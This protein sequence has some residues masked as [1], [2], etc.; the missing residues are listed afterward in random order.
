MNEIKRLGE[1]ADSLIEELAAISDDPD[2]LTRLFLSASHRRAADRVKAWFEEAGL[3]SRID[4][5]GTVRGVLTASAGGSNRKLLIG[6]HID[7]VVDAGK[8]DGTFGVIAGL[9]AVEELVREKAA[10]PFA[11]ELLAFGD[12]EGVRFPTT[13]ASSSAVAGTLAPDALDQTDEDG[14]SVREALVTF[15]GDP[16]RV[17]DLKAGEPDSLAGYLEV[18]IEQGPVL[19]HEA[20]PIGIVTALAA[21]RR[22]NMT[23]KGEAGHAG[24]V[25]MHLRKD[26][27]VAASEIIASFPGAVLEHQDENAVATVGKLTVSP[28][29]VNVIPG[30]VSFTFDIRAK[31][32]EARDAV[33]DVIASKAAD[34]A[35]RC[36]CGLEIDNYHRSTAT[37]MDA[38]LSDA[39]ARGV[40]KIGLEPRHLFS[41]AGH[42]GHAMGKLTGVGMLFVRCKDGISHN[43]AEFTSIEDMGTA[44]LALKCAILELAARETAK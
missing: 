10:L 17:Q 43:P 34:I 32:E 28:G 25:P 14:I 40:E 2:R 16:D 36:G 22:G 35:A 20:R 21:A 13:L 29:A 15:G 7:T 6:S 27:L 31:T 1:R 38:G 26:A 24:T 19:Q 9:L 8:Y 44:V 23:L 39:L 3:E 37:R 42:D 33:Y 4:A 41:G 11:V 12:E 5:L 30:E 18:H